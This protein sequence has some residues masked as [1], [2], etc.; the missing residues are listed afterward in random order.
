MSGPNQI[1]GN[2]GVQGFHMPSFKEVGQS[3]A[4]GLKAIGNAICEFGRTIS[5]GLTAL[6]ASLGSGAANA[7]N[8]ATES[9]ASAKVLKGDT[10]T[11]DERRTHME[12]A[13]GSDFFASLSGSTTGMITETSFRSIAEAVLTSPLSVAGMKEYGVTLDE[14]VAISMYTSQ[15]YVSINDGIRGNTGKPE[16]DALAAAFKSGLAKLPSFD[17]NPTEGPDGNTYHQC[18]RGAKLPESVADHYLEGAT[19]GDPGIMSSTFKQTEKFP[20]CN[21]DIV[22]L[23]KPG[24]EG[25][26][27]SMFSDK[28]TEC[29]VAFPPG[30]D[31]Q[32][33]SRRVDS[34][35]LLPPD[36]EKTYHPQMQGSVATMVANLVMME[37]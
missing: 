11:A 34:G 5:S 4:S 27:I 36:R 35:G 37:V 26:D 24:S 32:V 14:A 25:K 8:H 7:P 33:V 3:I 30:V 10:F 18:W 22:L 28:P 13:L 6:F 23:L 17:G 2:A 19:V 12:Q 9:G 15:A 1:G 20:G 16:I 31:F 21:F 29:E